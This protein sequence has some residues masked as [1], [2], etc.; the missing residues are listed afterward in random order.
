M[1]IQLQPEQLV[2]PINATHH[3]VKIRGELVGAKTIKP[4]GANDEG[5]DIKG[6][7]YSVWATTPLDVNITL[8]TVGV[9]NILGDVVSSPKSGQSG[10]WRK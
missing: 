7:K 1:V 9:I 3:S 2:Q 4:K 5:M 8:M 6:K 10:F